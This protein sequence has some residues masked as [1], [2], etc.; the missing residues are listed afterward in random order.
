MISKYGL[1]AVALAA[2]A[3]VGC[4]ELGRRPAGYTVTVENPWQVGGAGLP[5]SRARPGGLAGIDYGEDASLYRVSKTDTL[6]GIAIRHYG[7]RRYTYDLYI[8]NGAMLKEAG[9]LKRGMVLRLP[10]LDRP[11]SADI[12]P[13][14]P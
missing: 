4:V 7:D 5:I 10:K 9:G 12:F 14:R 2:L 1:T 13:A 8:V 11:T 6:P 3:A